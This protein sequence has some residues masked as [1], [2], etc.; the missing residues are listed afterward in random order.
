MHNIFVAE[1]ILDEP[2]VIATIGQIVAGGMA[3]HVRMD[4]KAQLGALAT[5]LNEIIHRLARHGA[6][7][8]EE[9]IGRAGISALVALA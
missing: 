4:V 8:T 3:E 7:F 1:I 6:A 5:L 9:E 2:G